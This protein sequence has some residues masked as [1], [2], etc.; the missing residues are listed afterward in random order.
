MNKHFRFCTQKKSVLFR[1]TRY[2]LRFWFKSSAQSHMA[3][4]GVI[5]IPVEVVIRKNSVSTNIILM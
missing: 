1:L 5:K 3:T 4:I 2:A